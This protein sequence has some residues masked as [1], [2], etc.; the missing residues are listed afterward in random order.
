MM[1]K[2][3]YFLTSAKVIEET[4]RN[5]TGQLKQLAQTVLETWQ[6]GGK[7]ISFGNGGS[8]G[9]SLHFTTELVARFGSQPIHQPAISLAANPCTVTAVANDWSFDELFSRQIKALGTE[10]D[11][12]FG[13]TTS[14]NS[15]NVYRGVQQALEMGGRVVGFTG[16]S[17]GRLKQLEID[18]IAIPSAVTAHVQEAHIV[19]LHWL[20]R[21]IDTALNG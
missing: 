12:Y 21:V 17:G 14:G 8:A 9:D 6:N 10:R 19:C 7:V 18:L 16:Q 20:C 13:L 4:G 1:I 11:I 2:D 3:D 5:F 15:E